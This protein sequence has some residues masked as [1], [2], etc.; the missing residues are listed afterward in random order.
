[1][2][3]VNSRGAD[4]PVKADEVAD[5][6]SIEASE[7]S[8]GDVIRSL[9]AFGLPDPRSDRNRAMGE[10]IDT[11][12]LVPIKSSGVIVSVDL[13]KVAAAD[14]LLAMFDEVYRDGYSHGVLAAEDTQVEGLLQT[15]PRLRGLIK[16]LADEVASERVRELSDRI[17]GKLP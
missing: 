1:M 5:A 4:K 13:K 16:D 17:E 15:F 6:V 3:T 14:V 12:A 8:V 2:S 9:M 10:A 11:R 7:Q